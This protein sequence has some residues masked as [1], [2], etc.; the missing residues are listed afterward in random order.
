[1]EGGSFFCTDQ[2]QRFVGEDITRDDEKDGDHAEAGPGDPEEGELDE[3]AVV[4]DPVAVK[5]GMGI[6]VG[7]VLIEDE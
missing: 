4:F 5:E 3:G 2:L 1:M 6:V 7:E